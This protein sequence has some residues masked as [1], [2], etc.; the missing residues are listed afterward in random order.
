MGNTPKPTQKMLFW[1][2]FKQNLI[3][4]FGHKNF[5]V[6]QSTHDWNSSYFYFSVT[7]GTTKGFQ[8]RWRKWEIWRKKLE[9]AGFFNKGWVKTSFSGFRW[10]WIFLVSQPSRRVRDT[11]RKSTFRKFKS[12]M[13]S[14]GSKVA[15]RRHSKVSNKL[16]LESKNHDLKSSGRSSR[17]SSDRRSSSRSSRSSSDRRSFRIKRSAGETLKVKS[18]TLTVD[19]SCCSDRHIFH[20]D[21]LEPK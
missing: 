8:P 16:S 2:T 7:K 21:K 15:S 12:S 20:N 1:L 17:L 18:L 13:T 10:N 11:R 5:N 3:E 6:L 14:F 19:D 9:S 4:I